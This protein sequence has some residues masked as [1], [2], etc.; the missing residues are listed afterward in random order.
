[1]TRVGAASLYRIGQTI[2][3]AGTATTMTSSSE[4]GKAK[5]RIIRKTVTARSHDKRVALVP[6]RRQEIA[7]GIDCHR[8]LG[9]LLACSPGSPRTPLQLGP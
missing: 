2:I 9:R 3:K 6:D 1:M 7:A 5:S 4:S 8:H